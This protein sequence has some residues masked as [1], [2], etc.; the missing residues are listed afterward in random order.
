MGGRRGRLESL[1]GRRRV[2]ATTD[3]NGRRC[4]VGRFV[5]FAD[6]DG[7]PH[8]GHIVD[9]DEENPGRLVVY[10]CG[11]HIQ[12]TNDDVEVDP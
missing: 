11:N 9:Y 10:C 8:R 3:R 2:S 6:Y 1:E 4:E 5:T 12:M 7:T